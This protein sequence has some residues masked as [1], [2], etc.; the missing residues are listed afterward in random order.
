MHAILQ[1]CA[2]GL[3]YIAEKKKR[4]EKCSAQQG[5]HGQEGA[6]EMEREREWEGEREREREREKNREGESE[7]A[8]RGSL[9]N[10]QTV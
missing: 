1:T 9:R 3:E 4:K 10:E 2:Q 8:E 5:V 7:G 6:V